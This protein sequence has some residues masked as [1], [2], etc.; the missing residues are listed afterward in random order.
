M[1][2]NSLITS[3]STFLTYVSPVKMGEKFIVRKECFMGVRNKKRETLRLLDL[4]L[5]VNVAARRIDSTT[6]RAVVLF[7]PLTLTVPR[8]L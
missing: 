5:D 3:G 4:R 7:R 8:A 6:A 2:I 1:I